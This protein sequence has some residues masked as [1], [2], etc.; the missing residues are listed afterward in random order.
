ML[1]CVFLSERFAASAGTSLLRC[2]EA[3]K[4]MGEAEKKFVQSAD[5]HFL[6]PLR[7]F[8][9]GQYKA[10]QV[11]TRAR[12]H[13]HQLQNLLPLL[14]SPGGLSTLCVVR[15]QDERRALLNKRLDL[16]IA[17][18]RLRKAREADQEARVSVLKREINKFHTDTFKQ[19][20]K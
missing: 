12:H 18:S 3:Q 4:Q 1:E 5:I 14:P 6:S 2:G 10:L 13:R 7:S 20:N 17:H 9:D 11:H 8:S 19:G 16:D 15:L